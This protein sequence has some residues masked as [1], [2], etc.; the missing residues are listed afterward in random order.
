[1]KDEAT[2][3]IYAVGRDA[4][5]TEKVLHESGHRCEVCTDDDALLSRISPET[6]AVLL[7]EELLSQALAG[8]LEAAVRA[9]PPWS[10]LPLL[11]VART[12]T[13]ALPPG[14]VG[15]LGNVAI[16]TRPMGLDALASAVR[17]AL[18][19]RHRQFEV[20]DLLLQQHEQAQRKDQFLAMLA[21][22]LRNPLAPI[23]YAAH[24][25][26]LEGLSADKVAQLAHLVERQIGHM[27]RIIDQLLDVSRVTQ[28]LIRLDKTRMD[29]AQLARDA[30]LAQS[31]PAGAKQV[32]LTS[33]IDGPVWITGDPTRLKQVI[34]NLIDNAVKFSPTGQAV[35]VELRQ[36]GQQIVLQ[37]IDKGDG[38]EPGL[39]PLLFEPFIQA[40]RSL[41]RS[42]GGLGL[43]LA[44]VKGLVELHGGT[45]SAESQG[46]GTGSAFTVT[47]PADFLAEPAQAPAP[48]QAGTQK[49]LRVLVAE[50]NPDTADT[51]RMILEG[52]G[53]QVWVASS[54]PAAVETARRIRPDALVCDIGLPGM[55]GYDVAKALRK[56]PTIA[57]LMIAVTGYSSPED[58]ATAMAAGFHLHLPK[59]VAPAELLSQLRKSAG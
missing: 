17:S 23:R 22:E 26:Q 14:A 56:D 20:R 50:D 54:G 32:Q 35:H 25:L 51:L 57:P 49:S 43:G 47:L 19:A 8:R 59:P 9:Q 40:D 36:E 58:K 6:G 5:L 34:D 13:L 55:S 10:D 12:S 38:I 33:R 31:I 45:V 16:L 53:Y 21:H 15:R 1:M 11:L 42:R 4:A 28:G 46:P 44:L 24:M 39:L 2:V 30:V 41:D 7:A 29:L 3:L 18:R 48:E 37:V 52:Y 27:G